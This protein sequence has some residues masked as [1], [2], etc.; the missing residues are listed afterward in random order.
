MV[1][2]DGSDWWIPVRPWVVVNVLECG[3]IVVN[4]VRTGGGDCIWSL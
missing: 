3:D 1:G 4:S 2:K